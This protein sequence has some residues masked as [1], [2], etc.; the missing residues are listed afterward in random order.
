M[1]ACQTGNSFRRA[2]HSLDCCEVLAFAFI[3]E[4]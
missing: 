4:G 3:R 2:E 1:F